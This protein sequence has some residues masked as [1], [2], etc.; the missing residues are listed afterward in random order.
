MDC[1]LSRLML[2]FRRSDLT[3][4]DVVAL[5][6]HLAG[7]PTCSAVAR[8]D[9]G[10]DKVFAAAMTAVPVPS[11]LHAKLMIGANAR[12]SAARWRK[13]AP[14]VGGVAAVVLAAFTAGGVGWWN[15]PTL[16]TQAVAVEFDQNLDFAANGVPAW[17]TEQGLPPTLLDGFDFRLPT[18]VGR[19]PL[20][21]KE[22]P[23]VLFLNGPQ[24]ARVAIVPENRFRV[25]AAKLNDA[26]SSRGN[27]KVF[28]RDG[29]YLVVTF[30]TDSLSPF[31][32]PLAAA[33]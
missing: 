6:S 30:T 23:T 1:H 17:L 3:A 14:W 9:A 7:C 18:F 33:G 4:E 31:L 11:G 26:Q 27:V 15:K 22:V 16:D 2:A 13:A 8:R 32:M 29:V 24:V 5:D 12:L 20:L 10:T 21:G 28:R 19:S 25:D